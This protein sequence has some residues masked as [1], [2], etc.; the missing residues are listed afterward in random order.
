MH[1]DSICSSIIN[2]FNNSI[3]SKIRRW[4]IELYGGEKSECG[5]GRNR[6]S[7]YLNNSTN[8]LNSSYSK[9]FQY[10]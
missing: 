8:N 1:K 7:T 10:Y 5:E 2:L 3:I 9:R 6:N 4:R